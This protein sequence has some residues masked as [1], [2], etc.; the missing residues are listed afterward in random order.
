[1]KQLLGSSQ[2]VAGTIFAIIGAIAIVLSLRYPLGTATAMG[3]GYFPLLLGGLLVFLGGGAVVQALAT[4]NFLPLGPFDAVPLFFM[5]AAVVA[6]GLLVEDWGLVAALAALVALT[7][8]ARLKSKPVE[9][10]MIFVSLSVLV[11]VIFVYGLGL[12]FRVF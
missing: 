3:P 10:L 12:Q 9:V 8:Y 1:M 5:L 6:F 7:C 2:V 4:R 11:V